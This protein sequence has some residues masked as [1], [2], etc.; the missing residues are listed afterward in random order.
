MPPNPRYGGEALQSL[1][2]ILQYQQSKD[3]AD[4][5]EAL[6][7]MQFASQRKVSDYNLASKMIEDSSK[8]NQLLQQQV[9]KNFLSQSGLDKFADAITIDKDDKYGDT[10]KEIKDLSDDLKDKHQFQEIEGKK[11][12]TPFSRAQADE[13]AS[14]LWTYKSTA[15]PTSIIDLAEDLGL[16]FERGQAA[17]ISG[18]PVK[19][20]DARLVQAFTG[21]G[22]EDLSNVIQQARASKRN[23]DVIMKERM[24]MFEGDLVFQEKLV[25]VLE[26]TETEKIG[27]SLHDMSIEQLGDM[28][29]TK[30]DDAKD[31]ESM[32]P[33]EIG[34]QV[35]GY[36]LVTAGLIMGEGAFYESHLG[37][38][39]AE[40][41]ESAK[42]QAQDMR[43]NINRKKVQDIGRMT[44]QEFQKYYNMSKAEAR[45]VA[46]EAKLMKQAGE[47]A[48]QHT[49]R[50][51]G[52]NKL[53]SPFKWIRELDYDLSKGARSAGAFG[54]VAFGPM[55]AEWAG[56]Q[57]GYGKESKAVAR[58]ATN[59]ILYNKVKNTAA[60]TFM[61]YLLR[62][63]P[64]IALKFGATAMVDSPALPFGDIVALGLLPIDI[65]YTY[66][67]WKGLY[68]DHFGD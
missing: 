39:T 9:A 61:N 17:T 49:Y 62:Q 4:V 26:P 56:E 7:L 51:R 54:M 60:P 13:I 31:P 30:I 58:A 50:T 42:K 32:T 16:A 14:A 18:Q 67:E 57:F 52:W 8:Y 59:V 19:T 41:F 22:M 55:A 24:E 35:A 46:G 12:K 45:T 20:E 6:Q 44:T 23:Q 53:T 28:V 2:R 10:R 34:E 25:S 37:K 47:Y 48:A 29:S 43:K 63:F 21:L 65:M 33:F 5:Q 40:Q 1:T 66:K 36:G 15:D 64:K 3:R 11:K 27:Q 68:G 38:I